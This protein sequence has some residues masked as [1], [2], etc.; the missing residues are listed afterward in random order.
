[1]E[2][3]SG[4]ARASMARTAPL[5]RRP[6]ADVPIPLGRLQRTE[7]PELHGVRL[8]ADIPTKVSTRFRFGSQVWGYV[9]F[10][11]LVPFPGAALGR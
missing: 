10:N 9:L 8:V 1:M 11:R 5:T 6:E 4:A 7:Q 2:T 3:T